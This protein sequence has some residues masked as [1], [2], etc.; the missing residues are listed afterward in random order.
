M[1]LK[2]WREIAIP[3]DDVLKGTFKQAEFEILYGEGTSRLGEVIDLGVK[4]ALIEKSGAWYSCSGTR[5]GQGKENARSYLRENAELARE[6]E[7]K[8]RAHFLTKPDT[9]PTIPESGDDDELPGDDELD[10]DL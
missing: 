4:A 7:A 2:P 3:H 6:L 8:I 10:A 5:I 1:T 9:L